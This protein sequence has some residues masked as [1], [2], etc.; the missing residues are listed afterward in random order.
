MVAGSGPESK[1]EALPCGVGLELLVAGVADGQS[2]RRR[3]RVDASRLTPEP[4]ANTVTGRVSA[5]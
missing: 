5:K 4:P 1:L 2:F 3:L